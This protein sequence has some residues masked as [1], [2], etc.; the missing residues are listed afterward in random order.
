MSVCVHTDTPASKVSSSKGSP[1]ADPWT[2]SSPRP[3]ATSSMSSERSTP[4]ADQPSSAT[5][6]VDKPVPQPTSRQRPSPVPSSRS[7]ASSSSGFSAGRKPSYHPALPSYPLSP[8]P[9]ML[10]RHHHATAGGGGLPLSS[11]RRLASV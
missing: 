1:S 11:S 4:T 2:T 9:A 3:R 7:R 8:M 10:A 5:A 6:A